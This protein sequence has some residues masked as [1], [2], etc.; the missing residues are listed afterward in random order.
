[1]SVS[2]LGLGSVMADQVKWNSEASPTLSL[3]SC[4]FDFDSEVTTTNAQ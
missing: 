1:M 3:R 4:V 2:Y